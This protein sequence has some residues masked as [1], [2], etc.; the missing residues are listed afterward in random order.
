MAIILSSPRV[1][2]ESLN[3]DMLRYRRFEAYVDRVLTRCEYSAHSPFIE[4][5]G[6][7]RDCVPIL[8]NLL[9]SSYFSSWLGIDI[10]VQNL[11]ATRMN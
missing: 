10:L 1:W 4:L 3:P 7:L 2:V 9:I 5:H 8:T 6:I 11:L